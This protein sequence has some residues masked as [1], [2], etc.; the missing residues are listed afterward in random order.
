V[1]EVDHDGEMAVGA[2]PE[3]LADQ[4]VGP[5][6][7]KAGRVGAVVDVAESDRGKRDRQHGQHREPGGD[8]RPWVAFDPRGVSL[9]PVA[10]LRARA[11]TGGL[12]YCGFG[13]RVPDG[14]LVDAPADQAQARGDQGDCPG[15]GH[16]D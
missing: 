8:E 9:P 1:G 10:G 6:V 16:Q 11:C 7:R 3:P 13:D 15:C 5:P 2:R 14:V 4:V 12:W